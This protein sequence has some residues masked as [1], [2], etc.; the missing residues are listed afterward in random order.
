MLTLWCYVGMLLAHVLAQQPQ[1]Q[2][3]CAQ[4]TDCTSCIVGGDVS[5]LALHLLTKPDTR[6]PTAVQV[7][8]SYNTAEFFGSITN[9]ND[10]F[11]PCNITCLWNKQKK[12]CADFSIAQRPSL[13][14][15][16]NFA[17][18][19]IYTLPVLQ[20]DLFTRFS[21][22]RNCQDEYGKHFSNC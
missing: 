16:A 20:F 10:A 19:L 4:L 2:C 17:T 14:P 18:P 21:A 3:A 22:S 11:V 9:T 13:Q 5:S 8:N 6:V 12:L 15:T 1:Q 7:A